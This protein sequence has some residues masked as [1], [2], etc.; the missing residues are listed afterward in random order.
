MPPI[1][2]TFSYSLVIALFVTFLSAGIA[3]AGGGNTT[4]W[5]ALTGSV[6]ANTSC[7]S[8][9]Y[10]GVPGVND[11]IDAA[12]SGDTIH[13][14]TG[15]WN[16]ADSAIDGFRWYDK[17]LTIEGDG[18][19]KT[20]I[21]GTGTSLTAIR[22]ATDS[23]AS[24]NLTVRD[25]TVR[26]ATAEDPSAIWADGPLV[27]EDAK[28]QNNGSLVDAAVAMTLLGGSL[29]IRRS[30][31]SGQAAGA[32]APAPLVKSAGPTTIEDSTF[33]DN[34]NPF[35]IAG[36]AVQGPEGTDITVDSSTFTGLVASDEGS[37]CTSSLLNLSEGADAGIAITNSTFTDNTAGTFECYSAHIASNG[38]L[39]MKNSTFARNTGVRDNGGIPWGELLSFTGMTLGNN[40]IVGD[41]N[42]S[43]TCQS[44]QGDRTNDAGNV[45]SDGTLGCDDWVGGASPSPQAK[46]PEASIDLQTLAD[47]GG[48]TETMALGATSVARGAAIKTECPQTDQRGVTRGT[49]CTSG[50]W[51][52]GASGKPK[53]KQKGR[54]GA[55]SLRVR[56]QCGGGAPCRIKL[57][58][59]LKGGGG[60]L[61][62]KSV[63]VGGKGKT[64]TLKYTD[65]LKRSLLAAGGSGKVRVR[66]EE[67]GGGS[68]TTVVRVSLPASVTG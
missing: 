8:P 14:C 29:T 12:N 1:R 21:D 45:I 30:T 50:A 59:A 57:T 18:Q 41:P 34:V 67:I 42:A 68:A 7:S 38:F 62:G 40:I 39:T 11:A 66:A 19:S 22:A 58:G 24:V 6:G 26:N 15:T 27:I 20:I 25:L 28:V 61:T 3:L 36:V 33:A 48:P 2:R 4:R 17:D 37:G 54:A 13:I 49:P 44:F 43:S 31:F 47:N 63:R 9:G 55:Q 23:F 35:P 64:V 46:V 52:E 60:K 5:V 51:Q 32:S 53:V 16:T 56:V 65:E 10:I